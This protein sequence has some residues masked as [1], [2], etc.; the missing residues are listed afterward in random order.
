[1]LHKEL[2][3]ESPRIQDYND[4]QATTDAQLSINLLDEARDMVVIRSAKY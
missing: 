2:E 3:Y 1:M 4:E